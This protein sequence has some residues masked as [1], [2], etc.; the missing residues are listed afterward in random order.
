MIVAAPID[1]TTFCITKGHLFQT[2]VTR[3]RLPSSTEPMWV[4][5]TVATE[6]QRTTETAKWCKICVCPTLYIMNVFSKA[7]HKSTSSRWN[8]SLSAQHVCAYVDLLWLWQYNVAAFVLMCIYAKWSFISLHPS[9]PL[10]ASQKSSEH[11]K[12]PSPELPECVLRS[13]VC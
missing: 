1:P 13:A 2:L 3:S 8:N 6:G 5:A 9:E 12:P 7:R 10:Q 4:T 11:I